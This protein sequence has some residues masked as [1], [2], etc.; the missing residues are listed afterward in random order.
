MYAWHKGIKQWRMGGTTYL[1]VPFTWLLPEARR[2]ADAT[3]GRVVAGGPAVE[4]L[5]D[6]LASVCE[7]GQDAAPIVPLRLHNPLATRTSQ[8]CPNA[9]RFCVNEHRPLVELAEWDVAPCVCDD[10]FLATSAAHFNRAVDRLKALPFVDFNQG[11]QASLFTDAKAARLSEL[12]MHPRFAWDDMR[13]ESAVMKA[14]EVAKKHGFR[15]LRC[16][17]LVG[18]N[19][20]PEDAG[21]RC[22]TLHDAGVLPNPMRYQPLDSLIKNSYVGPGWTDGTLRRFCRYWARHIYH[23]GKIPLEEF[24]AGRVERTDSPAQGRLLE[25]NG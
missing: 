20:S 7:I 15:D 2:I 22:Q 18:F 12:P 4:L 17:V 19:D 21:Y 13:Y 14:I 16:Y 6:Y 11:L 1:S 10:N 8:G 23:G 5:P 25:V 24:D 3:K 9:C